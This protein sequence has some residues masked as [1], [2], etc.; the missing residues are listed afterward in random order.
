MANNPNLS[1]EEWRLYIRKKA[2]EYDNLKT[3]DV[4]KSYTIN[5]NL[6]NHIL[7]CKKYNGY[8]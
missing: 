8:I 6:Y 4:I 7:K 5:W 1:F 3:C 2:I